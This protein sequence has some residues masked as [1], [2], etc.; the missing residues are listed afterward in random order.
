MKTYLSAWEQGNRPL[1]QLLQGM[2]LGPGL[3]CRGPL[4]KLYPA[5]KMR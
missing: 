3:L 1:A 4:G 2:G 5:R